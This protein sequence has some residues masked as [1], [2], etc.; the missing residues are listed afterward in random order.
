MEEQKSNEINNE[1][2]QTTIKI[3]EPTLPRENKNESENENN[4]NYQAN[5]KKMKKKQ[6][7][8]LKHK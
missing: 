4:S 1:N 6:K 7:I 3:E 5:L 8:Y 2:T